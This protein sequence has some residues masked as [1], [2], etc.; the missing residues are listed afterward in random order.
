MVIYTH[1]PK[2][3]QT[4]KMVVE[5]LLA[6]HPNSCLVCDK[7]NLCELRKIAA[8]LEVGVPRFRTKKRYYPI[9]DNPYVLRDLTKCILCRRCVRVCREIKG[10]N[11]FAIAYRGHDCKVVVDTDQPLDKAVCQSCDICVALCP[12]GALS[13]REERFL[14]RKGRPLI[15]TSEERD[16]VAETLQGTTV[17]SPKATIA[18]SEEAKDLLPALKEVQEERGYLSAQAIADIAGRRGMCIGE[19]YGVASFYSFLDTEPLG[20]NV[21]TV[22]RSVPCYLSDYE[23]V[24]ETIES[25]LGIQPGETTSDGKFSLQLTN[26]IGACDKAPAMMV[27]GAIYGDL[28]PQKVVETLGRYE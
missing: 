14:P 7:A 6:S 10:E 18:H 22:C 4:R 12:V 5:L 25:A 9:E 27:N 3:L 26:C 8:D 2:A 15:L 20:R 24:V 11:V 16:G 21:I 13:K 17:R 28:T 1:S 23:T 19:V